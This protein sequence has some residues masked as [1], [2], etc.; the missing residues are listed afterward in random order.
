M[1]KRDLN[2]LRDARNVVN[3]DVEERVNEMKA[4]KY[5]IDSVIDLRFSNNT[6]PDRIYI[7]MIYMKVGSSEWMYKVL[8]EKSSN[9]VYMS[10][11]EITK[12]ISK[13]DS[14]CY[15]NP[16]IQDMYKNGF[17]FCGNNKK[18]TAFSRANSMVNAKYIKHIILADAFD[19]DNNPMPGYLGLWV[20]YNTVIDTDGNY[21][22]N[23]SGHYIIK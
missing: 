3:P 15:K 2:S 12:F 9:E 17:R 13:K 20:Q 5:D 10:E 22:K 8:S 21:T 16:V 19:K 18:D 11:S 4:P 7:N 1:K 14:E 23:E 6:M